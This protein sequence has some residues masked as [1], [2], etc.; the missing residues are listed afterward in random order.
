[1]TARHLL[2]AVPLA[3]VA[4]A[5][6]SAGAVEADEPTPSA[7]RSATP[8]PTTTLPDVPVVAGYAPGEFPPIPLISVPDI[9]VLDA[10]Q[11]SLVADIEGSLVQVPGLS[12]GPARCAADGS[13][14]RAGGTVLY[15]DGSGSYVG[16]D[17]SAVIY[18][19]GSGSVVDGDTTST[20][21]GDG[22]GSYTDGAL[23]ITNYGDG[24]GS[25]TDGD[26]SITVYGDGSGSWSRGD[27]SITN[28][29]DG[30][31]SY[32]D[33]TLSI[34]NYGDGSGSYFDGTLSITNYG[35]GTGTIDGVSVDDMEPVS[36]VPAMGV[37]P[38]LDALR[39][40]APVCG[41]LVTLPDS[42]LFDFGSDRLRPEAGPVLDAVAQGLAALPGATGTIAVH[43]H[44]DSIS[45][46]EL[47]Q[48]LSERR[49]AAVTQG[50][51][52]RGLTMPLE[53]VGHG[54]S[55]PVAPNTLDDGG[56]NPAG[57]QLNRR[58]EILVPSA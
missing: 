29:G 54:E 37:F 4:L 16:A 26:L 9:S 55:D 51:K 13:L 3:L 28:Y 12:V 53:A 32:T 47:N 6:C 25:Y 33:G 35:D 15:G 22:S 5:G 36:P 30:S 18:G 39:P 56:D 21:Y 23:S 52:E 57:R 10:S 20:N 27:R 14:V 42:V 34:T 40:L 50:L 49:A 1:V 46:D 43:G 45:S 31:G 24:S 48:A 17:G 8:T 58:V 7:S 44:T 41:T 19:D 38:P 11:A 2:V